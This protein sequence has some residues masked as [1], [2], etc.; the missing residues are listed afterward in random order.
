MCWVVSH[1][2]T[3][4]QVLPD[5]NQA[6][7][8]LVWNLHQIK[9]LASHLLILEALHCHWKHSSESWSC[10][11]TFQYMYKGKSPSVQII[12]DNKKVDLR[13]CRADVLKSFCA[14]N[15]ADRPNRW[16]NNNNEQV[17]LWLRFSESS[18]NLWWSHQEY[19]IR[20]TFISKAV[21]C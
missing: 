7:V 18:T 2:Q 9:N 19:F 16:G 20:W 4:A 15:S 8:K 11:I 13:M 5:Q 10:S 1:V 17:V 12:S 3:V 21:R 14:V 6:V